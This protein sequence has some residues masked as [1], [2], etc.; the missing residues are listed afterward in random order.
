MQQTE[1]NA[2]RASGIKKLV[3]E[4]RRCDEFATNYLK[5]ETEYGDIEKTPKTI[6]L[7]VL[8]V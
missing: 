6:G 3:R 1:K 7:S 5:Q 8:T 4:A 2:E